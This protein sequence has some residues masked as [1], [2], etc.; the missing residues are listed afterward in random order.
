MVEQKLC[1]DC[2]S[3]I[4]AYPMEA[5]S[6]ITPKEAVAEPVRVAASCADLIAMASHGRS[7]MSE[8]RYGCVAADV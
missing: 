6:L 4:A 5:I 2:E 8:V 7:G 1:R 3:C